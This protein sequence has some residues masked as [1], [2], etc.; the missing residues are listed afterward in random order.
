MRKKTGWTNLIGLV[1]LGTFGALL[2]AC[3]KLIPNTTVSFGI[4]AVGIVI[5]FGASLTG[6]SLLR[7]NRL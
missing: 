4:L 3:A 7:K 2:S 5:T 6:L 1:W